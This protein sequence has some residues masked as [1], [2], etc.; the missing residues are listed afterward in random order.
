[1]NNSSNLFSGIFLPGIITF[2]SAHLQAQKQSSKYAATLSGIPVD[3]QATPQP[4]FVRL[5]RQ[6]WLLFLKAVAQKTSIK[7]QSSEYGKK[8]K[9]L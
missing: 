2:S 4:G 9:P 7:K 8:K 3:K 1:M 6:P 5:F